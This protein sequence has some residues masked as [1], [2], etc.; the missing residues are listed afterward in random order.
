MRKA[1]IPAFLLV[2]TAIVLG[3]TVFREQIV[4]ARRRR[5]RR[6]SRSSVDQHDHEPGADS[7]DRH[8]KR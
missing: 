2:V 7:T 8:V 3:S 1:L 6:R 5:R 4:N